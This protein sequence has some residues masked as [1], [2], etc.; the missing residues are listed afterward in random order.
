VGR[1]RGIYSIDAVYT[2]KDHCAIIPPSG[3]PCPAQNRTPSRFER[4]HRGIEATGGATATAI[5]TVWESEFTDNHRGIVLNNTQGSKVQRNIFRPGLTGPTPVGLYIDQTFNYTVDCNTFT[6]TGATA[7]IG[8]ADQRYGAT[9]INCGGASPITKNTFTGLYVGAQA[10]GSNRNI[11]GNGLRYLSNTFNGNYVGIIAQASGTLPNQG[12]ATNQGTSAVPAGNYFNAPTSYADFFNTSQAVNY[13]HHQCTMPTCTTTTWYPHPYFGITPINTSVSWNLWSCEEKKQQSMALYLD[14]TEQQQAKSSQLAAIIDGGNT[15]QLQTQVAGSASDADMQV[16]GTLMQK[17]PNLSESVLLTAVERPAPLPNAML[18]DVLT[19]NPQAGKSEVVMTGLADRPLQLPDYMVWQVEQSSAS[20]SPMENLRADVA[21]LATQRQ[22]TADGLL[23]RWLMP[24]SGQPVHTD[25]ANALLIAKD[26]AHAHYRLALFSAAEGDAQT[27]AH[28]AGLLG[29]RADG[30]GV[31][32]A[33]RLASMLSLVAT[34][35]AEG[36]SIGQYTESELAQLTTFASGED[37]AAGHAE[38]ILAFVNGTEI[39]YPVLP[40]PPMPQQRRAAPSM[41]GMSSLNVFPNPGSDHVTI[42]YAF[43][44][45]DG[46]NSFE[47]IDV[48]GRILLTERLI[49]Q[50]DQM[51]L[52]I[53]TLASGSY[54]YRVVQNGTTLHSGNFSVVRD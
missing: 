43:Q 16:Y 32:A 30:P 29:Q 46:I 1:G 49:G 37:M 25:S 21:S 44:E 4:L 33:Q 34:A 19:S 12:I 47:V 35:K 2:V 23:D 10:L 15:T 45:L 50:R 26:D 40:V 8:H 14:D 5:T 20:V 22:Q 41:E 48:Q 42:D 9:S 53:R 18:R 51:I 17:S 54:I 13:Y 52:D 24:E 36:R 7:P 6:T 3:Q 28:H 27:A 38:A 39:D 11:S 31:E